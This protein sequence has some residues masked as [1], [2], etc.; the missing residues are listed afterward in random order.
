MDSQLTCGIRCPLA[1]KLN[2]TPT[3]SGEISALHER[4]ATRIKALIEA[5]NGLYIKLGQQ[6]GTQAAVLPGPYR[7][8]FSSFSDA[9]PSVRLCVSTNR[10]V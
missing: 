5:N 1:V 2:F 10:S 8:A 6:L 4:T 3:K 7:D 9:A